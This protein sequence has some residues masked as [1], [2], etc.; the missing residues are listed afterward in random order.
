MP[1][2]ANFEVAALESFINLRTVEMK[3]V[4]SNLVKAFILS[5]WANNSFA[6]GKFRVPEIDG[7][8]IKNAGL[9]CHNNL[10]PINMQKAEKILDELIEKGVIPAPNNQSNLEPQSNSDESLND[11]IY[12]TT[13]LGN[14]L[15]LS[16]R[17]LQNL[18][19]D[20][21]PKY[22]EIMSGYLI[23]SCKFVILKDRD[24][25]RTLESN[26]L[27]NLFERVANKTL[28]P[29]HSDILYKTARQQMRFRKTSTHF[30]LGEKCGNEDMLDSIFK[31]DESHN[32]LMN[33]VIKYSMGDL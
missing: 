14:H 33:V 1:P 18:T 16:A 30:Q 25:D 29:T 22:H 19:P 4:D 26:E 23:A 17:F 11:E 10:S 6:I 8:Y 27:M 15:E 2:E 28:E 3:K 21:R 7:R 24:H 12:L 9:N 5:V 13:R 20:Q 32:R 31:N